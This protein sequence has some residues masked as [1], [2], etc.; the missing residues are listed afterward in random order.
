MTT[1]I[2]EKELETYEAHKERL[3]EK[4]EGK[5]VLIHDQ[6]IAGTFESLEDTLTEGYRRFGNAPFLAKQIMAIE[7]PAN[8]ANNLLGV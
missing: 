6:E 2:L 3:L 4:A 8:F 1:C 7:T 5:Y